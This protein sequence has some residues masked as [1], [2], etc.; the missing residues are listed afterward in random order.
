MKEMPDTLELTVPSHPKH[1]SVTRAVVSQVS[2]N[3][4]FEEKAVDGITLAVEEAFTNIIKHSYEL[5][6]TKTVIIRFYVFDDRLE[7]VMK[8]FGK[9]VE[10]GEIKPRKL[11]E[12][13][14]GGLGV[15]FIRTFMDSVEYDVSP[16]VGTELR[17]VKY[18]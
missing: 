3:M 8:D 9:K 15:R 5:D 17:L 13:R 7:I 6:Y 12:V 16:E 2:R 10:P 1:G 18:L 11:E 14:P 4:D